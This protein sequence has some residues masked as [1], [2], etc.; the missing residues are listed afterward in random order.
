MKEKINPTELAKQSKEAKAKIEE[1]QKEL[2]GVEKTVDQNLE[3]LAHEASTDYRTKLKRDSAKALESNDTQKA[4]Q[5]LGDIDSHNEAM[6]QY[7]PHYRK[8]IESYFDKS[9]TPNMEKLKEQL[10]TFM[11]ETLLIWYGKEEA[12]KAKISGEVINPSELDLAELLKD[13]P[14]L[15]GQYTINPET[16]GINHK[17]KEPKIKILDMAEYVGQPRSEVLK[18]V[19]EKYGGQLAGLE[20]EMYLLNNPDKVPEEMKDGNWY[21]F[22]GSTLRGQ[23]GLSSLPCVFWRGSKLSRFAFWLGSEWF[24]SD[25]VVLLEK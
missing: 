6:E 3:L 10:N 19:A 4:R 2:S 15:F 24:G 5:I 22:M 14:K 25:R 12:D 1:G 11:A 13:N 16:A 8:D 21:Y 18:A 20:Y 23:R 17:E 7:K 9:G